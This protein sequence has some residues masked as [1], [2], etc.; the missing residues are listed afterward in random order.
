M[1]LYGSMMSVMRAWVTLLVSGLAAQVQQNPQ[2]G[3]DFLK[4]YFIQRKQAAKGGQVKG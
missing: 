3:A 2:A 1:R 4:P